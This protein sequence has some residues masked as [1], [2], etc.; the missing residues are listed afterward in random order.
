LF[1]LADFDSDVQKEIL[2][3]FPDADISQAQPE[4]TEPQ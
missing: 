4:T 2:K 1:D 3:K